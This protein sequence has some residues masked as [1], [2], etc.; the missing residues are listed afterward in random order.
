ME[1]QNIL[2]NYLNYLKKDLKEIREDTKCEIE[3]PFP[4]PDGDSVLLSIE[5]KGDKFLISD[6]GF[7]DE[8]L[9]LNGLDLW[10]LPDK[11]KDIFLHLRRT[12]N[13]D[14]RYKPEIVISANKNEL[15]LKIF[16]LSN[17]ISELSSLKLLTPPITFSYFKTSIKMYLDKNSINYKIDPPRFEFK[18]HKSDFSFQLDFLFHK[19]RSYVKLISSDSIIKNWAL[20][21]IKLKRYYQLTD[22]PFQLWVI[23]NDKD[24]VKAKDIYKWFG[25]DM[26]DAFAWH[27]DKEKLITLIH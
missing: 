25:E 12:Y 27:S 8:Y 20:R 18:L 10:D 9:F 7:M 23:Y 4:K 2:I 19:N 1:C 13:I 26:D 3:L 5:K 6:K 15:Y 21:F 24:G 14:L 16:Q 22:K 11:P 17:I